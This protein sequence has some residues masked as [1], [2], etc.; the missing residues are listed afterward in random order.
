MFFRAGENSV[1]L[2]VPARAEIQ[3]FKY[4]LSHERV[5]LVNLFDG[6]NEE[7]S[8]ESSK[9]RLG[10]RVRGEDDRRSSGRLFFPR[11][12]EFSS[13]GCSRARG[14]PVLHESSFPRTWESRELLG[15][16]KQEMSLKNNTL[17]LGPR[18]HGEDGHRPF[19]GEP[20][21]LVI[22]PRHSPLGHSQLVIRIRLRLSL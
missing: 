16:L 11:R 15:G 1:L 2:V 5:N 7:M 21:R 18:V 22:F 8:L 12:R 13:I 6:L 20:P 10:P 4:R 19:M 9:L 14:N 3:C 17:Q